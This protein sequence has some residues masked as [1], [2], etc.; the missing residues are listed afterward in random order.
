MELLMIQIDTIIPLDLLSLLIAFLVKQV[1]T[2]IP[3]SHWQR[4]HPRSQGNAIVGGFRMVRTL[5]SGQNA[6]SSPG[7]NCTK[8]QLYWY[9]LGHL[10][11]KS[12][13]VIAD[14]HPETRKEACALFYRLVNKI[15]GLIGKH[16]LWLLTQVVVL[17]FILPKSAG[18][19]SQLLC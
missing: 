7:A 3:P 5:T 9:L 6:K 17:R 13:E 1:A 12:W 15:S 18:H 2:L 14:S 10:L 19:I 4:I 8:M 16:S 11:Q